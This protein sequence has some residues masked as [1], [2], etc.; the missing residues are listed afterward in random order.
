M[1]EK[2]DCVTLI[3]GE[4]YFIKNHIID[5]SIGKAKMIRYKDTEVGSTSGVFNGNF[6]MFFIELKDWTFYRYVSTEEY[7][8]KRKDKY[9]ETCLDIVLKRVV[10]ESFMW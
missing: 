2:I 5:Y 8:K 9:D 6:G 3:P 7:N 10:N 4:F 1:L